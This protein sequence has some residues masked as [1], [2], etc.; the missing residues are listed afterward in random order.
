[1]KSQGGRRRTAPGRAELDTSF[2]QCS[3]VTGLSVP[4]PPRRVFREVRPVAQRAVPA[5]VDPASL[6]Q[7]P[8]LA[9]ILAPAPRSLVV[10]LQVLGLAL[11][12]IVSPAASL[13]SES[14]VQNLGLGSSNFGTCSTLSLA[15][16]A[17]EDRAVGRVHSGHAAGSERRLIS[18]GAKGTLSRD[19]RP[20]LRQAASGRSW[21]RVLAAGRAQV[22]A[23]TMVAIQSTAEPPPPDS[24]KGPG[25]QPDFSVAPLCLL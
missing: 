15:R 11:A 20:C 9:M 13:V 5:C 25:L 4:A 8:P 1:M 18:P 10:L 2:P 23:E 3:Q 22:V 14:G 16:G 24:P 7:N 6:L 17:A 19:A 21:R 12:Q